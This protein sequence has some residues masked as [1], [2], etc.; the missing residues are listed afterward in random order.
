MI[1]IGI[2]GLVLLFLQFIPATTQASTLRL[3]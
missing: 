1:G 3:Y 2:A